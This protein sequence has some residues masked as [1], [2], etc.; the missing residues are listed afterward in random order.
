MTTTYNV[1]QDGVLVDNVVDLRDRVPGLTNDVTYTF[2]VRQVI[3]GVE[4][5]TWGPKDVTPTSGGVVDPPPVDP[6][7]DPPPVGG[8]GPGDPGFTTL[9]AAVTA[10]SAG[11]TITCPPGSTFNEFVTVPS[12]KN[13]LIID[14]NGSTIDGQNTRKQWMVVASNTVTIK[15]GTMQNAKS[16]DGLP[17]GDFQLG[18]LQGNSVNGLTLDNLHL[19]GG[20]A[21]NFAMQG[22]SAVI[23][24]IITATTTGLTITN[25][26]IDNA[27]VTGVSFGKVSSVLID[28]NRIHHNNPDDLG[29]PANE[30]G[31]IKFGNYGTA[32]TVTNNEVDH[33]HGVGIWSDVFGQGVEIATNLVHHNTVTGIS[34]EVSGYSGDNGAFGA[35]SRIHHNA[36]WENGWAGTVYPFTGILISSAANVQVDHNTSAWNRHAFVVFEQ[37]R[38]IP[39]G[40]TLN[41][42]VKSVNVH[43]N[44]FV[45]GTRT[46]SG[47]EYPAIQWWGRDD[48]GPIYT[49]P[50]N[51]GANNAH[52]SYLADG[53]YATFQWNGSGSYTISTWNATQVGGGS[54]TRIATTGARDTLL[55]A[56]GIPLAPEAH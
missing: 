36:C 5:R 8:G 10:A 11:A 12:G 13:G 32:I 33:N 52:W 42:D 45:L 41:F 2:L 15:N 3:D 16:G 4:G 21:C 46:L 24:G 50:G 22:T 47:G 14:L 20:A 49:N 56:A 6:P 17:G 18:S 28:G 53:A 44:T 9:Q 54:S 30:A 43:D 1:Y 51:V 34:Y 48:S 40:N 55:T 7:P 39:P 27:R 19:T 35:V 25:C 26:E 37:H 29:D 31:G 38:P 23:G